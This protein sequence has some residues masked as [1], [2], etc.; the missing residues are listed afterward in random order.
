M[1]NQEFPLN[2]KRE[3]AVNLAK[4]LALDKPED[5]K[6]ADKSRQI[7]RMVLR[8]RDDRGHEQDV[9]E[10]SGHKELYETSL[11]IICRSIELSACRDAAYQI[12]GDIIYALVFHAE[13]H[14]NRSRFMFKIP[15]GQELSHIVQ[16]G[17]GRRG[18]AGED[19]A[20]SFP[21]R[22]MPDILRYVS[23]KEEQLDKRSMHLWEMLMKSNAHLSGV[24]QEYTDRE[25]R[26]R[27]IEANAEDHS[28]ERNKKRKE[29]E[30]KEKQSEEMWT[31]I[32]EGAPKALPVVLSAIQRF[33]A[34]PNAPYEPGIGDWWAEYQRAEEAKKN[35]PPQRNGSARKNGSPSID[36]EEAVEAEPVPSERGSGKNGVVEATIEED[37]QKRTEDLGQLRLRVAYDSTRFVML[38]HGRT[39]LAGVRDALSPEQRKILD[40]IVAAASADDAESD[41]AVTK[42]SDLARAFGK[43]MR[44]DPGTA[45]MAYASLDKMCQLALKELS[46]LLEEFERASGG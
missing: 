13:D 28:Y 46:V 12:G 21:E 36:N 27:E 9:L 19:G 4:H 5:A 8:H 30:R 43:A 18:G 42:I 35:G 24:V 25:G 26:L 6:N 45:L 32:K 16:G 34:G 23:Q 33:S 15:G 11:D 1:P 2:V 3:V 14:P 17:S 31:L 39:K 41:E 37:P 10:W 44:A 22:I 40:D 20:S 38:A 7:T 29:D